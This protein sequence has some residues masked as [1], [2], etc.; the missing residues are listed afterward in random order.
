MNLAVGATQVVQIVNTQFQVFDKNTGR[1]ALG[2]AAIHT[3]FT[4]LP[5]PCATADDSD[6]QV[7]F[8]SIAG[9]WLISQVEYNSSFTT[10]LLCIAV[11][12]TSDAT[13]SYNLYAI[14]F[15]N[16]LPDDPRMGVWPDG[17]YLSANMFQKG[18]EF[19]GAQACALDRNAMLIGS[20]LS[21][22]CFQ[23]DASVYNLIPA[24]IDGGAPFAP[25]PGEPNFF[26]QFVATG[27]VGTSLNLY[28][29]HVDWRSAS[30]TFTGPVGIFVNSFHEAFGD[31]RTYRLQYRNFQ[32]KGYESL[33]VSHSVQVKSSGNQTGM[34][35]YEIRSPN[36]TPVVYQESTYSP[37]STSYRWRGSIAQDKQGNM[38]MGYSRSRGSQY[39]SMSYVGRNSDDP[40]KVMGVELKIQDGAGPRAGADRLGDYGSMAIDP[41]DDCTFWYSTEYLPTTGNFNWATQ[42]ASFKFSGCH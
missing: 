22:L 3:V 2:P 10:N 40:L 16:L 7:L 24:T 29:L 41:S 18:A 31:G 38:A 28:K 5:G 1:S 19:V 32:A 13:G 8:D 21:A 34:R 35:W 36:T 23:W 9:R 27:A 12:Q 6:A 4:N 42:I 20:P 26:L 37:D 14:P 17:Y 30:A 39:P 33:M 15:G 11:S 25:S